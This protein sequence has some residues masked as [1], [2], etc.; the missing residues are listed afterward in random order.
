M[1]LS[2]TQT[3]CSEKP[4]T[5]SQSCASAQQATP[6]AAATPSSDTRLPRD[7]YQYSLASVILGDTM[8]QTWKLH[9][10]QQGF[11]L[12]KKIV[13]L[14]Y[15]QPGQGAEHTKVTLTVTSTEG[16]IADLNTTLNLIESL[17]EVEQGLERDVLLKCNALLFGYTKRGS[18]NP[19][20]K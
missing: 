4:K 3:F 8:Y 1:I 7:K 13:H 20:K 12:E 16:K 19:K 11:T 9:D 2:A 10:I 14:P 5:S 17:S 18:Y 6:S 15:T